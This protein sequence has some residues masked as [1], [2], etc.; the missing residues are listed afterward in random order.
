MAFRD[1][2]RPLSIPQDP[3]QRFVELHDALDAD[4][5]W[6]G[7]RVPLRY[8]AITMLTTPGDAGA[9]ADSIREFHADFGARLKW[10]SGI[11]SSIRM[12]LA[13][14]LVKYG[15]TPAAFLAEVDR[16]RA[17]FRDQGLRRGGVYEVLGALVLRRALRGQM[18]M[19]N[20]VA[21]FS[22][23]YAQLK[24]HHWFLT[25]PDDYPAC[26]MLMGLPGTPADIGDGVEAVYQALR[27]DADLWRG[28]ALQTAS[29]VLYLSGMRPEEIARR[30]AELAAELKAAGYRV[31]QKDYDEVAVL[32]FLAAPARKLVEVVMSYQ[33]TIRD[34]LEWVDRAMG[35]SLAA[36]L[37]FVR[38][39]G[40]H[41]QLG[42][43]ADAKLML[44]MQAIVAARQAAAAAAAS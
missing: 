28:D 8:A 13:A 3:L 36:S 34:S 19:P 39:V 7:D 20:H 40:E 35:L 44:D 29:N 21:R 16:V 25:G 9:I 17:M 10:Y 4:R 11:D 22:E 27:R 26:A 18:A 30:F 15:D 24:R 42:P 23:I 31:G 2:L 12:V 41:E 32:C 1:D 38:L 6:L 37:A 14:Q 33:R 43:L 5:G